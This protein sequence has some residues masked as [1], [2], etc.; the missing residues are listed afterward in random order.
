M[1][2]KIRFEKKDLRKILIFI[3]FVIF[4]IFGI[5]VAFNSRN[6][7]T[8]IGIKLLPVLAATVLMWL[9]VPIKIESVLHSSTLKY[10]YVYCFFVFFC[11]IARGEWSIVLAA[12]IAVLIPFFLY[13]PLSHFDFETI[14]SVITF[15]IIVTCI[16]TIIRFGISPFNSQGVVYAFAGIIGLNYL[17]IK[18]I[19]KPIIF[20]AIVI[21]TLVI[22]SITKSRT[23]MIS[24]LSVVVI[25]YAYLYLRK[26]T[27]K[28]VLVF[29]LIIVSIVF[30]YNYLESFFYTIFFRKWGN[31]DLTSNRI[32]IWKEIWSQ[33]NIFGNGINHLNGGD[34]HN[35]LMQVLGVSGLLCAFVYLG[36]IIAIVMNI[37][38]TEY[39]VVYLNFFL[40]WIIISCFE[41][42]D[43]ITSRVLSVTFLFYIHFMFLMIDANRVNGK[44][45]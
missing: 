3:I 41:N 13:S 8:I 42:L 1:N 45:H 24:F 14:Y 23:S 28:N 11:A 17:C 35:A 22:I 38:K 21:G 26:K 6:L 16:F 7:A 33:K 27:F 32:Y 39:K 29:L 43:I 30:L 20:I 15:G 40:G 31:A 37:F 18:K 34:A 44:T 4:S 5:L 9:V 25:S 10:Y 19:N 2:M 36:F 12:F